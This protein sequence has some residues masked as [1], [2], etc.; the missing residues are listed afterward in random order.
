[1]AAHVVL[2]L[3]MKATILLLLLQVLS[4]VNANQ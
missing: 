3:I 1:M 4:I 2:D